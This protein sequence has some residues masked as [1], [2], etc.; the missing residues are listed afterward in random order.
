M[1]LFPANLKEHKAGRAVLYGGIVLV[2]IALLISAHLLG[3]PDEARRDQTWGSIDYQNLPEVQLLQEYVRIDTNADSGS[4][5]EGAQFLATQLEEA[6]IKSTIESLGERRANLWAIIEGKSPE[7]VVLHNHIDVSPVLF[8]EKW[9]HPPFGGVL[10]LAWLYGRGSFDMKSVAIAQMAAMIDL[11]QSGVK[12]ER[13]V[14]FLAT[15]GEES[16]SE[17]GSRWILR[18]HPELVERFWG[19]LSE[20]GVAEA[21]SA[22]KI[23]YWGIEIGQRQYVSVYLC[24]ESRSQLEDVREALLYRSGQP[25]KGQLT[26]AVREFL[27]FWAPTRG[28][29][30]MRSH[31]LSPDALAMDA[32]ELDGFPRHIQSLFRSEATPFGVEESPEGGYQL[33]VVIQLLPGT[34]LVQIQPELLPGWLTHGLTMFMEDPLQGPTFS[35][36]EHPIYRHAKS[37]LE[38]NLLGSGRVGPW[39]LTWSGT[40]A[41]FFRAAGIP[42]YGFSP[43]ISLGTFA[44]Q[45]DRANERIALP[46]YVAGVEIYA[47][48]LRRLAH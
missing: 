8:P 40:D 36:F 33:R 16:G 19:V 35:S 48:L 43:F 44:P 42:A 2:F 20:G 21:S 3:R 6:G 29:S 22:D 15:G 38:E 5:L 46:G 47:E 24:G 45:I 30:L 31:L 18:Q 1:Q 27:S 14:I 23:T 17:L 41:R 9:I 28:H 32:V 25:Q 34:D 26:P 39:I 37:V 12:P 4:E 13:S 10:D 7:A 11:K